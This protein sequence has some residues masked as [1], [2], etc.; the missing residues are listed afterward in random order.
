MPVNTP[1]LLP[2]G[3]GGNN[4]GGLRSATGLGTVSVSSDGAAISP[5]YAFAS[6]MSLG[7]FRSGASTIA[8]SYGTTILSFVSSTGTIFG[9]ALWST[10]GISVGSSSNTGTLIPAISSISSLVGAFVVQGSASSFTGIAW[11]AAKIGD[12]ILTGP[13]QSGAASSVSSGLVPWSHVTVA[14]QIEFRLS[15]VSTLAQNQSAQTWVFTRIS[16]F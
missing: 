3:G 14:G 15:N 13:F 7:W 12:I 5:P 6:E 16:P 11:P 10:S 8:Q 1:D 9:A 2:G 4:P